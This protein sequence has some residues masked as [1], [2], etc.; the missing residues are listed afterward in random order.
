MDIY[1]KYNKD[2][3]FFIDHIVLINN[4]PLRIAELWCRK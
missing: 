2:I 3:N 1:D 4:L